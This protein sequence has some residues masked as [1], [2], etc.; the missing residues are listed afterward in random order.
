VVFIHLFMASVFSGSIDNQVKSTS[1]NSLHTTLKENFMSS[2]N[3]VSGSNN[4]AWLQQSYN[5]SN[6]TQQVSGKVSD[7][8]NDG[9]SGIGGATGS[10]PSSFLSTIVQALEQSLSSSAG[11][12]PATSSTS[13]A[14]TNT[15]TTASNS[16]QNPEAALQAFM[17]NLFATIGQPGGSSPAGT[18]GNAPGSTPSGVEGHRGHHHD[19][20]QLSAGI[21]SLLQQLNANSSQSSSSGSATDSNNA[22]NGLNSSFQNL[23]SSLDATQG[24]NQNAAGTPTLQSFLQNLMQNIGSAQNTSGSVVS[25]LA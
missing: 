17:Q 24:V 20:G 1:F 2:I 21:Q 14:V 9:S 12:S 5:S 7:G 25:T 15:S 6:S 18:A 23:V 8:D 22:L 4:W 19:G 3:G 13:S 11:S 10:G 16:A